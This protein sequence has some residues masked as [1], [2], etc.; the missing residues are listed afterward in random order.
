MH[1]L[2]QWWCP[3]NFSLKKDNVYFLKYVRE[4]QQT[5]RFFWWCQLF[6]DG[7][8]RGNIWR[9]HSL[10]VKSLDCDLSRYEFLVGPDSQDKL[11]IR[12]RNT[13]NN[14]EF[15]CRSMC[16]VRFQMVSLCL[17]RY[18]RVLMTTLDSRF[19]HSFSVQH[20]APIS[21]TC[22]MPLSYPSH[23]P[24]YFTLSSFWK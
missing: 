16:I 4:G 3:C 17:Q 12:N 22:L 5:L 18:L 21:L 19:F 8:T 1:E 14:C 24:P 10:L 15:L 6:L 7:G 20:L 9:Q 11:S 23:H 2:F 13:Q